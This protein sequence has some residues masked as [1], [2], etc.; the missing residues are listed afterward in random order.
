MFLDLENKQRATRE[1]KMTQVKIFSSYGDSNRE[2][3]Q[4]KINV[5]LEKEQPEVISISTAM[6]AWQGASCHT[7]T[8]LYKKN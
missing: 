3:V 8:I 2:E 5:W 6:T 4:K 7:V 1:K